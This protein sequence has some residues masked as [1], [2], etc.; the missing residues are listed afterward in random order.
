MSAKT[1][2][3]IRSN[4]V[5]DR[6]LKAVDYVDDPSP[7]LISPTSSHWNKEEKE[8]TQFSFSG[9]AS[10]SSSSRTPTPVR[11]SGRSP[12]QSKSISNS[13]SA[14]RDASADSSRSPRLIRLFPETSP[15]TGGGLERNSTS[16]MLRSSRTAETRSPLG[17][18]QSDIYAPE[19]I[20][21]PTTPARSDDNSLNRNGDAASW[22]RKL[23]GTNYGM[24]P[25]RNG[26]VVADGSLSR[27]TTPARSNDADS[28]NRNGDAAS[29]RRRLEG[30]SHGM[31]RSP[32]RTRNGGGVTDASWIKKK[33]SARQMGKQTQQH[34][35]SS[36]RPT[37]MGKPQPLTE[38]Q[39]RARAQPFF[40][41]HPS[42]AP[43]E[44]VMNLSSHRMR[45]NQKSEISEGPSESTAPTELMMNLSSQR[46][47]SDERSDFTGAL[48]EVVTNRAMDLNR[49]SHRRDDVDERIEYALQQGKRKRQGGAMTV[50]STNFGFPE[51][52]HQLHGRDNV[53]HFEYGNE[54]AQNHS[55]VPVAQG[56]RLGRH[57]GTGV[58]NVVTSDGSFQSKS[59]TSSVGVETGGRSIERP[60]VALQRVLEFSPRGS[61]TLARGR[62]SDREPV[63]VQS[64]V[65]EK[66]FGTAA[67]SIQAKESTGDLVPTVSSEVEMVND[68]SFLVQYPTREPVNHLRQHPQTLSPA[69]SG[70]TP[71]AL[72]SGGLDP[73]DFQSGGVR[74]SRDKGVQPLF[75][76]SRVNSDVVDMMEFGPPMINRK[77]LLDDEMNSITNSSG[78]NNDGD[79]KESAELKNLMK[80]DFIESRPTHL[81]SSSSSYAHLRRQR[82]ATKANRVNTRTSLGEGSLDLVEHGADDSGSSL[83]PTNV[84]PT[85]ALDIPEQLSAIVVQ[86]PPSTQASLVRNRIRSL[87]N[88]D[89]QF[90]GHGHGQA[91]SEENVLVEE[92]STNIQKWGNRDVA[93]AQRHETAVIVIVPAEASSMSRPTSATKSPSRTSSSLTEKILPSKQEKGSE[94]PGDRASIRL[95]DRYLSSITSTAE[96]D[97]TPVRRNDSKNR[98]PLPLANRTAE[99]GD[100]G[101]TSPGQSFKPRGAHNA[102]SVS[103]PRISSVSKMKSLFE[104]SQGNIDTL[105]D[106]EI[107]DDNVSVKSIRS[108]FEA[109]KKAVEQEDIVNEV[110]KIRSMFERQ[111]PSQS[112]Q[113]KKDVNRPPMRS[114]TGA[115]VVH[116]YGRSPANAQTAKVQVKKNHIGAVQPHRPLP[117]KSFSARMQATPSETKLRSATIGH[118]HAEGLVSAAGRRPTIADRIDAMKLERGYSVKKKDT[119]PAHSP[120]SVLMPMKGP[121]N[122]AIAPR[123][124]NFGH[125]ESRAKQNE[126]EQAGNYHDRPLRTSNRMSN[127]DLVRPFVLTSG[128]NSS[129]TREELEPT[130]I[131]PNPRNR[132]TGSNHATGNAMTSFRQE[133]SQPLTP[134]NPALRR[135]GVTPAGNQEVHRIEKQGYRSSLQGV[136][137]RKTIKTE[138]PR[139]LDASYRTDSEGYDDGVTLDLSIADVSQLTN[140]T[141]LRSKEGGSSEGTSS[142]ASNADGVEQEGRGPSEAS[143]SQT[144]EAA[145]PLIALA[146]RARYTN[147]SDD[148]GNFAQKSFGERLAPGTQSKWVPLTAPI[149]EDEGGGPDRNTDSS[150]PAWD[151]RN[152]KARFAQRQGERESTAKKTVPERKPAGSGLKVWDQSELD[153]WEP[154]KTE[155]F[156]A[157]FGN[158]PSQKDVVESGRA[159]SEPRLVEKRARKGPVDPP[160]T[161][162]AKAKVGG[163]LDASPT[164]ARATESTPKTKAEP[165]GPKT[166]YSQQAALMSKLRSLKEA[167]I[168]RNST[169][170]RKI[171][172]HSNRPDATRPPSGFSSA[173]QGT[174][175][176]SRRQSPTQ[177]SEMRRGRNPEE[178]E[179]SISTMSSTKFGGDKFDGCLDLD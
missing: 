59:L 74:Y 106:D 103:P 98:G 91:I 135:W 41:A 167:R 55:S 159:Q 166:P 116:R 158:D 54:D 179:H 46:M 84:V 88:T 111:G 123:P 75:S 3:T 155:Q 87:N 122:L 57:V 89:E 174:N 76:P 85:S 56:G 142:R 97:H 145:A 161:V 176:L 95:A 2:L 119:F 73:D 120:S 64:V 72:S 21:R 177:Y 171:P 154:F 153:G 151:L 43:T 94:I 36:N 66:E 67:T 32:T 130:P 101:R 128:P 86:S 17:D 78:K 13:T 33:A 39:V 63:L 117:T 47:Q 19:P 141:C 170:L 45:T 173:R 124:H 30:T 107:S 29:W 149:E 83:H 28:L 80:M 129:P 143:S 156:Q 99:E 139:Y 20:S 81:A 127:Q 44:V 15:S 25:T 22:R 102:D 114:P 146:M 7:C 10:M 125:T 104:P 131:H 18:R 172:T 136:M 138:R 110:S 31:K 105:E 113:L 60:P 169:F 35:K 148:Y 163:A 118:T 27:P 9:T 144:S 62:G 49:R 4:S 132:P 140:P 100:D 133:S 1:Q 52:S 24:K 34:T 112:G 77:A 58:E 5:A 61:E 8:E 14:T 168:R 93:Q 42:A 53:S 69:S 38:E 51:R 164:A 50:Q 157:S 126:V 37:Q 65:P 6:Y 162:P 165:P 90:Q 108:I 26:G 115:N 12:W 178:E 121:Q 96:V 152:I 68:N 92:S 16:I 23:E 150:D 82:Q 160:P 71:V 175:V 70:W 79:T 109:E 48:T 40:K 134:E 137:G 11:G 147:S